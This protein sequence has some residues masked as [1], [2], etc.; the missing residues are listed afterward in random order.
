MART[1]TARGFPRW[2]FGLAAALL[3]L[4]LALFAYTGERVYQLAWFYVALV[5]F[6][7]GAA[8][9]L[10][11][12]YDRA[13]APE[14]ARRRARGLPPPPPFKERARSLLEEDP[15]LAAVTVPKPSSA[16]P[17]GRVERVRMSCPSCAHVFSAEG[18]RPLDVSCP[19]CG[20]EGV[21]P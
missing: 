8:G 14:L 18:V 20:L 6:A 10:F 13:I 17:R 11:L 3:G 4:L 21:L 5:G 16:A 15:A 12:G 2:T 19:R 7:L 1:T 9:I